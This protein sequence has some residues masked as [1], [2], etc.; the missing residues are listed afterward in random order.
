MCVEYHSLNVYI[1][2]PKFFCIFP[3]SVS[4]DPVRLTELGVT[5]IVNCAMGSKFNQI[6]TNEEYF[7]EAKIQ[8]HGITATDIMTY[9]IAPH[10]DA[11]ADFI[12]KALDSEGSKTNKKNVCVWF[13]RVYKQQIKVNK[14]GC[15]N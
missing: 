14:E 1:Y 9:K 12:E 2:N 8:F 3:S 7:S 11:A 6:N 15:L 4:R 5:H 10:F 13:V